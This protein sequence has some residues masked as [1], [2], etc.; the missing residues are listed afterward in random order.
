MR[1]RAA[2]VTESTGRTCAPRLPWWVVAD[3]EAEG[4]EQ[5][6][7]ECRQIA[8]RQDFR[9]NPMSTITFDLCLAKRVLLA[10]NTADA[11]ELEQ[12][13][14]IQQK[15]DEL[16][17]QVSAAK[18]LKAESDAEH[19]DVSAARI[20]VEVLDFVAAAMGFYATIKQ[21]RAFTPAE[22]AVGRDMLSLLKQARD[23][24]P[25]TPSD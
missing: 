13:T 24:L 10:I 23:I 2:E 22:K 5:S 14:A 15:Y 18:N 19:A 25:K 17:R 7:S 21:S 3:I 4:D 16:E 6:A 20:A 8:T 9:A 12:K 11:A 1:E